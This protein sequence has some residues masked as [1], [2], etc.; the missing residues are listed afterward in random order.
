MTRALQITAACCVFGLL[1]LPAAA[2]DAKD[3][4]EGVANFGGPN[5]VENQLREDAE[6]DRPTLFERWFEWKA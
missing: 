2:Q 1:A 4:S 5:S 3:A 6:V